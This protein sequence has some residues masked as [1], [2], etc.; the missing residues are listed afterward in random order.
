MVP[1]VRVLGEVWL[2]TVV[3]RNFPQGV[4]ATS[5]AKVHLVC[6]PRRLR[7]VRQPITGICGTPGLDRR[8][9]G[10]QCT[11][12]VALVEQPR[13]VL[14]GW[15]EASARAELPVSGMAPPLW[16]RF[17]KRCLI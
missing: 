3:G 4:P 8:C 14:P 11:V 13:P 1:R 7:P 9:M 12:A 2:P 17:K 6:V 15:C 16:R 5:P 10:V